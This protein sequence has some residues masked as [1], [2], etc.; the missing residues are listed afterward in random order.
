[1]MLTINII[2]VYYK[3]EIHY[4]DKIQDLFDHLSDGERDGVSAS[5]RDLLDEHLQHFMDYCDNNYNTAGD[6]YYD[7]VCKHCG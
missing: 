3:N 6:D 4:N 7:G 5:F 2:N 1:M